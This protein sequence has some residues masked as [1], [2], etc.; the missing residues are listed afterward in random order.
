M[1]LGNRFFLFSLYYYSGLRIG[2]SDLSLYSYSSLGI[3][4]YD[5]NSKLL[6]SEDILSR[7]RRK[8]RRFD[9]VLSVAHSGT[10]V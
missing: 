7:I 4:F 9:S 3:S 6:H 1:A 10:I 8:R 2:Y 5:L